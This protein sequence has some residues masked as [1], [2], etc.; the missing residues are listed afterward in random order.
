MYRELAD[1]AQQSEGD[2]DPDNPLTKQLR[3]RQEIELMKAPIFAD[4]AA[5]A[6]EEGGAVAVFVSFRET[7]EKVVELL[8]KY[9]PLTLNVG[10]SED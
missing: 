7:L 6:I 9:R 4:L 10:D 3:L 5:N 2:A 1:L 8:K